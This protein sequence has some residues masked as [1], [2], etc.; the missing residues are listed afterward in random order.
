M[1]S[2]YVPAAVAAAAAAA[3]A[4]GR[5]QEISISPARQSKLITFESYITVSGQYYGI[6]AGSPVLAWYEYY[7]YWYVVRESTESTESTWYVSTAIRR[8]Q[9]EVHQLCITYQ[10]N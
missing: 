9:Y 10:A 7:E 8:N 2:T 1:P 6:T 4:A 3:A 5:E